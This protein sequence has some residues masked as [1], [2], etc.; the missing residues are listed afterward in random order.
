VPRQA[1]CFTSSSVRCI[2]PAAAGS[3][4]SYTA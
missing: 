1:S 4:S 2:S 3:A